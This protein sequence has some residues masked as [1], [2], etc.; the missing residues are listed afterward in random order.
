MN[1]GSTVIGCRIIEGTF[2]C[3]R[4]PSRSSEV[5]ATDARG[6]ASLR[7]VKDASAERRSAERSGMR[8]RFLAI[9]GDV[10]HRGR[11]AAFEPLKD[12]ESGGGICCSG[13]QCAGS[14]DNSASFTTNASSSSLSG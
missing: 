5:V 10:L 4:A 13:G 3:G 8:R 7:R 1:N 11:Q 14:I 2:E 12:L 6:V 9:E